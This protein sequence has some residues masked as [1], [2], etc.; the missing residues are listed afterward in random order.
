M[1]LE[2]DAGGTKASTSPGVRW[3]GCG[4][5]RWH[6]FPEQLFVKFLLARPA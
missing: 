6:A 3:S 4:V 2:L 1:G 5:P